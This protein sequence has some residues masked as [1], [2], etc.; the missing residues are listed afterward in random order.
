MADIVPVAGTWS[1]KG[2]KPTDWCAPD[3]PFSAALVAQGH[4]IVAPSGRPFIWST[5]L[6][7][8]GVGD[9]DLNPWRAAGE[10]LFAYCVPP[11]AE[12]RRI[13]ASSLILIAHSHGGQVAAAALASGLKAHT[14]VTVSTPHRKDM[15]PVYAEARKNVA[16]WIHLHGAWYRDTWQWFGEFFDGRFAMPWTKDSQVFPE[17]D[18]VINHGL[19]HGAPLRDPRHFHFVLDA[20]GQQQVAV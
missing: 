3:S 9:G 8:V 10:N 16:R 2:G 5:S 11:L 20:L 7:G 15:A 1:W 18:V 13:P 4:R 19:D 6:G 12:D 14:L 17:A